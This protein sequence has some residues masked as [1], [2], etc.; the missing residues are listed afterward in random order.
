MRLGQWL[1]F[2]G[3][4]AAAYIL[5]Q[6]RQVMLLL[7][8]A[9]VLAVII[10]H[11][12][13]QLQQR[14]RWSR[15]LSLGATLLGL[16]LIGGLL[17]AF[18]APPL[19]VQFQELLRLAPKGLVRFLDWFEERLIDLV[20]FLP[21]FSDDSRA[22]QFVDL[23]IR[24]LIQSF[25]DS[26]NWS[27]FSQ[28]LGPLARNF[29]SIFNN[30]LAAAAQL[31]LVIILMLML[32]SNPQ[33]YRQTFLRL[34]PSF[35]RRRADEVL[36]ACE[37]SLS[38][39]FLGIV[40]SSSAIALFSWLGLVILGV[41]LALVNAI[42]AGFL[43]LIPN[44]GPTLSAIFPILVV[45]LDEPWKAWAVLILYI[46]IQQVESYWLTP[47]IMARQVSL[48]PALTLTS[49]IVF[50]SVFGLTGL[51]LALPL[52]VVAKVFFEQVLIHDVLDRW[53][54]LHHF[55]QPDWIGP[56]PESAPPAIAEK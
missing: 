18:L 26:R 54:H 11:L 36:T 15:R 47:T 28:Q 24:D 16:T 41:K 49:Q 8:A 3:I 21:G 46:L 25:S 40:I 13:R 9:V 33:G 14:L 32:L 34:L 20:Q 35:Y 51:I 23:S 39:W 55:K 38:D 5:W 37:I 1:G 45:L 48:L 12:A 17:I 2:T 6:L 4:L 50:A 30:T 7:F 56:H 53:Q 10:N 29:L 52:A 19:L 22:R 44:L 42:I 27:T 31:L 43:N